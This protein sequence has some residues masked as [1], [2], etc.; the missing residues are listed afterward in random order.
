MSSSKTHEKMKRAFITGVTGQDG[1]YL[2]EFLIGLGYEVHGL[3]WPPVSIPSSWLASIHPLAGSKLFLHEGDIRNAALF[4]GVIEQTRPDEIYHLAGQT[5][6]VDSFNDP[7]AALDLNARAAVQLLETARRLPVPPR[8]FHASSAEIFGDPTSH[9]QDENTPVAP[10][11]PY[12]CA[13]AY[14]TEMVKL[15]RRTYGLF[16]CN[17]IFY[18]HESPRRGP[19]FVTRRVCRSAAAIKLG[20]ESVLL[21]GDIAAQRDWGDARDYVRGMWLALQHSSPEDYVFS[22]GVLHSVQDLVEIAFSSLGLDWKSHIRIDPNFDRPLDSR[23]LMGDSG[24]AK[25]LLGWEPQSSFSGLIRE[26][27]QTELER[28][29][30]R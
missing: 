4:P 16:A 14:A 21:L 25:R 26:M 23:R 9:P 6:V 5:H 24:K 2:A 17:G 8:I 28:L 15:Y 27:V 22:T 29:R 7:V 19:Q 18:P 1:S 30:S 12:A 3:V 11:N 10:L 13:K 20:L